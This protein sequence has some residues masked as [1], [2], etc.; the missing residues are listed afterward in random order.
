MKR[1]VYSFAYLLALHVAAL[2]IFFVFRLML[3]VS[4]DY[5]FPTSLSFATK[6]TAFVKGVWFDNVIACYISILPLTAMSVAMFFKRFPRWAFTFA[7]IFTATLYTIAF[8]VSAANIP[9]FAYFFTNINS[10]IF[11]WLGYAGTTTGMIVGESSYLL[12]IASGIIA[13]AAYWILSLGLARFCSRRAQKENPL[14]HD[15]K[16]L[17]THIL[18]SL[19]LIGLCAFGIRGRTGYNPIKVSQAYYCQDPLLNQLGISPTFNLLTSYM[20]DRRKENRPI[21]LLDDKDALRNMQQFLHREGIDSISPL[22]RKVT[23]PHNATNRKNVVM[24]LMESMSARLM[25]AHGQKKPLTPFLDSLHLQSRS[26]SNFYSSGI[27]TNHGITATLYSFPTVLNR[28]AMKGTKIPRYVGLPDVL[29]KNGYLNMFFMTHESQY[30]NMNA[31]LRTNGFHEI[32]A[33]EDY[34]AG[35]VVNSFGV[36]DKFLF[37]YALDKLNAKAT[38]GKPFFSVILTI[39]NHPP[40]II[41]EDFKSRATQPEDQIVE[42]AD[43]AIA[44]FMRQ[45]KRQ[46]W[47]DN[48]IFIF[49]G[50]HGKIVG[51]PECEMPQSYNHVPFIIHGK[52]IETQTITH[53]ASQVDVAP[54]LL[55]ML[56]LSY[57]QNNFGID[58][59]TER[60]DFVAFTTDKQIAARDSSRLYIYESADGI[61]H[62]YTI[63]NGNL[64]KSAMNPTFSPLKKFCFS[65]IQATQHFNLNALTGKE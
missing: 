40:Y 15:I 43:Q 14:R 59:N 47:Y 10:S 37:A 18:M 32:Y 57:T 53:L 50:D 41:P 42:Y 31:F 22:A 17:A 25:Q 45:A 52:G 2:V 19:A 1:T 56:G 48:T 5:D 8:S 7:A 21:A 55:S 11:N 64:V 62:C 16:P 12:P 60:R 30:D 28:N 33:Q 36:P 38:T 20:D 61:E 29:A 44:T 27:H 24:V 63:T 26:Y 39:S 49:L 51:T 54:T 65:T 4:I 46:P 34:P 58:L 3:F 13:I 6:A 9:Y 35:E 23:Y